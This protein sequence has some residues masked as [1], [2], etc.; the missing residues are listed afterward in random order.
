MIFPFNLLLLVFNFNNIK[1]AFLIIKDYS[2]NIVY[3]YLY[4]Y[5]FKLLK[6]QH[7]FIRIIKLQDLGYFINCLFFIYFLDFLFN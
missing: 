6:N 5:S 2:K 1:L 3:F 7:I 4:Y